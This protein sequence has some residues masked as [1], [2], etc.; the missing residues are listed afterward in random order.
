[1]TSKNE[2]TVEETKVETAK[3]ENV[4]EVELTEEQKTEE[5]FNIFGQNL[6]LFEQNVDKFSSASLKKVLKI[7]SGYPLAM[8]AEEL[9]ETTTLDDKERSLAMVGCALVEQKINLF[10]EQQYNDI[11]PQS[12]E[13]TDER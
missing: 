9:K 3:T 13:T 12:K 5:K 6:A 1:M 8:N 2:E 4:E 11:N 7:V 10:L